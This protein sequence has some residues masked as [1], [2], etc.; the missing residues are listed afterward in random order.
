MPPRQ[1]H[2]LRAAPVT[3]P[4]DLFGGA[5]ESPA[6]A[7]TDSAAAAAVPAATPPGETPEQKLDGLFDSPPGQ[8]PPAQQPPPATQKTDEKGSNDSL[9]NLFNDNRQDRPV[10]RRPATGGLASQEL[11]RWTD[12]TGRYSCQGRLQQIR[13]ATVR[14]LKQNGR[15]T[16]VSLTRLSQIDLA[17]VRAEAIAAAGRDGV[18]VAKY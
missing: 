2:R 8:A 10:S 7:P 3:E 11:R 13:R 5:V 1:R 17:F 9:E 16:T 15:T 14:I 6:A 18:R 12:N 4:E